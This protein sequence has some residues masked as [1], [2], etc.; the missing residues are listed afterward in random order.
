MATLAAKNYRRRF[1]VVTLVYVALIALN[2]AI[3]RT[4]AP[5]QIVLGMMAVLT[6]LPI[7]GMIA[8]M[9]LY[10]RE[11]T[12]EFVR[13]R[14]VTAMLVAIGI[15]LSLTSILGFLQFEHIVGA[16]PV[17]FAFPAWCM[18][19]GVVRGILCARDRGAGADA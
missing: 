2:V 18:F 7:V 10:I 5:P 11:E 19:F 14:L 4:F 6:S 13:Y 1:M 8:V 3:S 15:L 12:D 9:G 17:F 16:V